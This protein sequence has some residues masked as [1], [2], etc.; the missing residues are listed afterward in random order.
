MSEFDYNP[1][2]MEMVMQL[3][4]QYE[5]SVK[6]KRVPFF[7]QEDYERIIEY[8]EE[9]GRFE[10]ALEVAEQALSQYPYSAILLL[11]KAQVMFEMKQIDTALELLDKAAIFDNSEVGI[12]LLRAEIYTFQ[13]R[14]KEAIDLLESLLETAE[15]DDLPDVY[16]QLCDVYEDWEKYYE[17][18]DCLVA[19]LRLDPS[20]EEALN[21]FNYC[22]EI[23]ERFE[24]SIPVHKQLIDTDPYNYLA[25]YNLGCAYR[26]LGRYMDAIDAF[27]Y[28][29]AIQEEIDYVFQDIAELYYKLEEYDKALSVIKDLCDIFEA[30]DEIYLLQGKCHEGKGDLKMARYCYRKAAHDNPG[31]SEAYFRIGETYK[32]EGMWEQAY[33]AFQKAN[34]LEKQHYDFCLAMAEAALEIGE[35]DVAIDACETAIDIFVNRHEAYFILAKLLAASG[36]TATARQIIEKG[37]EIAKSTIE[38]EYAMCALDFMENHWKEGEQQLRQLVL[39]DF[40]AHVALFDFDESLHT[41]PVVMNIL[42]EQN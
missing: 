23:T 3:V 1:E 37:L 40:D 20:N 12:Y 34:D 39:T 15:A 24:D 25:W 11:K 8:Y 35:T 19:C 16:L 7:D 21:R 28:V 17:V 2:D 10:N 41:H 22:V 18:Y 29:Q 27:E 42:A 14:Y 13:S 6:A 9:S 31:L 4:E 33:K 32:Q 5:Q 30:D 36:E 26:G 38:L